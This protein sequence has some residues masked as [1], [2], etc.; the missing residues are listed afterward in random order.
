MS[1]QEFESCL[2]RL[3]DLP[4]RFLIHDLTCLAGELSPL[5]NYVV[6]AIA[7]RINQ[8]SRAIV[9]SGIYWQH[10]L[11]M[12]LRSGKRLCSTFLFGLLIVR[13]FPFVLGFPTL[14]VLCNWSRL[15]A[16]LGLSCHCCI[17]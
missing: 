7:D 11:D 3:T 10:W 5:A 13:G 15:G 9:G 12:H 6:D 8:V 16:M 2:Q 4:D 14:L 1:R 17:S